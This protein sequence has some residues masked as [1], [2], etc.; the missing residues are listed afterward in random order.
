MGQTDSCFGIR[1]RDKNLEPIA[2]GAMQ[3]LSSL[4]GYLKLNFF[5][6]S[7]TLI[8]PSAVALDSPTIVLSDCSGLLIN[9]LLGISSYWVL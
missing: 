2:D 9:W 8:L 7:Q 1:C 6:Y 5:I 3:A 4:Q